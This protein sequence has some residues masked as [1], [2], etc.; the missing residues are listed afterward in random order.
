MPVR[1]P[2][3]SN[4]QGN[5]DWSRVDKRDWPF[6][7][8]KATE[9]TFYRDPFFGRNWSGM[10]SQGLHRIAYHFAH[11]DSVSAARTEARFFFNYVKANGGVTAFDVPCID[12]EAGGLAGAALSNYVDEWCDEVRKLWG[13]PGLIYSGNWFLGARGGNPR[14]AREAGWKL[15]T[16]AYGPSPIVFSGFDDYEFWQFTD[17]RV[18]PQPHSVPGIGNCDINQGRSLAFFE[19][20]LPKHQYASRTLR[21]GDT[22]TDVKRLQ[23]FVNHRLI[24]N[25]YKARVVKED[26]VYGRDT[27]KAKHLATYLLGF[28]TGVVKRDYTTKGM[29]QYIRHPEARKPLA[30]YKARA[31]WRKNHG[32]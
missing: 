13:R 14:A 27:E 29:Q 19:G 18:G 22:G 24:N 16:A 32:K 21:V 17:G 30:V 7:A 9:G 4:H 25:G 8:A 1:G 20:A 3:V 2:D 15:W 31:K 10:K 11:A 5:V 12:V 6:A 26:G 28:P 23:D